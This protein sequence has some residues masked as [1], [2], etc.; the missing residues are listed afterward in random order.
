MIALRPAAP[1]D[2][3]RI[4]RIM[5]DYILRTD[6]IPHIYSEAELIS[7]CQ[8]MI[9]RGW[10]TVAETQQDVVGFLARQGSYVHAIYVAESA[11]GAGVGRSLMQD[12]QA[13]V[14]IL[15]LW[16]FQK[17]HAAQ[18]FYTREGFREMRRTLG[19]GNDENLPDIEYRW[20]RI[21]A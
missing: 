20:E 7:C 16:A 6:W 4:A 9:E 19:E 18:R 15:T 1:I 17:G 13:Q 12:A 2:A 14:G 10:V 11:Q 21:A 3:V 5:Q 8:I